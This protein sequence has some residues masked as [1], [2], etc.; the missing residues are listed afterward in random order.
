MFKITSE[1]ILKF[2]LKCKPGVYA[3]D[4]PVAVSYKEALE[5]EVEANLSYQERRK[6]EYPSIYDF[7]DAQVKKNSDI[8]A[9][10]DA[11]QDQEIAYLQECINVKRKYPKA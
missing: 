1:M 9:E 2:N 10:R 7:I 6:R 5:V 3:D 4:H 11:G 8:Q